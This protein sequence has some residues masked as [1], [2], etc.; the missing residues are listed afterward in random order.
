MKRGR[1]LLA[2]LL[3]L[4]VGA[5]CGQS[6]TPRDPAAPDMTST[7]VSLAPYAL[8]IP[9]A[10]RPKEREFVLFLLVT[11]TLPASASGFGGPANEA[12]I[13]VL[14]SGDRIVAGLKTAIDG[15]ATLKQTLPSGHYLLRPKGCP[16][17]TEKLEHRGQSPVEIELV[18]PERC[19]GVRTSVGK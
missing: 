1:T 4:S 3:L 14:D 9:R 6:T 10:G 16:S 15:K 13:E 17:A 12:E 7:L 18:M 19:A 5:G 2:V 11:V 8:A